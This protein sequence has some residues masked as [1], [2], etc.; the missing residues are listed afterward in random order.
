MPSIIFSRQLFLLLLALPLNIIAGPVS[1]PEVAS[2]SAKANTI[3]QQQQQTNQQPKPQDAHLNTLSVYANNY[4]FLSG[5]NQN[6]LNNGEQFKPSYKLPDMET[7]FTPIQNSNSIAPEFTAPA[8]VLMQYLPQTITEGGMQYLQLIP[9]RPLVVPIGPYLT[10]GATAPS[11]GYT[12]TISAGHPL[13]YSARANAMLS[14]M[15]VNIPPPVPT[16]LVE[17][18]SQP[19]PAYGIPSYA[20]HLQ[21]PKQNYR[22][23]RETKDRHLPGP[24]NLNLNEYMPGPGQPQTPMQQAGFVRGRP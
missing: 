19:L 16:S 9:T 21:A 15:P 17:V 13:E 7:N 6:S 23:N 4:D 3:Q 12:Q 18:P 10:S 2:K 1:N 14:T 8:P 11:L 22:I 5:N 24:L 20:A